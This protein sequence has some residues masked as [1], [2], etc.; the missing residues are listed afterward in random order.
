[1]GLGDR[2]VNNIL[3]EE[4]SAEVVHIDFG[5]AFEQGQV[6]PTPERVPFRLTRDMIDGMGICG[7][8]GPFKRSCEKVLRVMRDNQSSLLT[9][10]D[11]LLHDPLYAWVL[12][13]QKAAAIQRR[14]NRQEESETG[15]VSHGTGGKKP[16][17]GV[18]LAERVLLRLRQKLQGLE[19][20]SQ[21]SIGGQVSLLIQEATNPVNLSRMYCGWQP[22]L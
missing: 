16:E 13:P 19:E 2:H 18:K 10:L 4:E 11:V 21:L 6:L 22:Y 3:I 5:I 17:E 9:I 14:S 1:L 12:S 20:N 15:L 7:T 8:E